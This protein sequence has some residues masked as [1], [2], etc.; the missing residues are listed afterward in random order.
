MTPILAKTDPKFKQYNK[1]CDPE[2]PKVQ[3]QETQ[4]LDQNDSS[5]TTSNSKEDEYGA[6]QPLP[7]FDWQ[8]TE[9][10]KYRPYKPK[11]HLTMCTAFIQI[12]T[13]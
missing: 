3:F 5:E 1:I 10:R 13:I 7:D 9:P 4:Q 2:K 11:Y 6:V 8:M 12:E